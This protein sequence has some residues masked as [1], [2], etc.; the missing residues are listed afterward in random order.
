MKNY[1]FCWK[2]TL[3]FCELN[4]NSDRTASTWYDLVLMM[5]KATE[6]MQKPK[7]NYVEAWRLLRAELDKQTQKT[8]AT[9][10]TIIKLEAMWPREYKLRWESLNE[11]CQ[12]NIALY[13]EPLMFEKTLNVMW[14]LD[15]RARKSPKYGWILFKLLLRDEKKHQSQPVRAIFAA[16]FL[17]F[18]HQ[19]EE[20]TAIYSLKNDAVT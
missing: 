9:E 8:V 17:T 12:K 20:D 4:A 11:I 3:A 7:L 18:A 5:A 13:P 15:E 2:S 6:E 19:L 14:N 16:K 1:S 10:N